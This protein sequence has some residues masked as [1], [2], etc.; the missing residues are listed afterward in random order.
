VVLDAGGVEAPDGGTHQN[1]DLVD[2]FL[3]GRLPVGPKAT[4]SAGPSV[5]PDQSGIVKT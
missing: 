2:S 3:L 5:T 4:S 1:Q